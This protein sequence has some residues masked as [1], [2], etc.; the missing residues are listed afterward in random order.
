MKDLLK[1]SNEQIDGIA[2]QLKQLSSKSVSRADGGELTSLLYDLLMDSA[3]CRKRLN[4]YTEGLL[5][6]TAQKLDHFKAAFH[7]ARGGGTA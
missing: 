4:D 6:Q 3:S 5:V 1:L 2:A 7:A